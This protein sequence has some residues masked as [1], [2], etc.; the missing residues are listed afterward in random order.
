MFPYQ[1]TLS[2]VVP[3]LKKSGLNKENCSSQDLYLISS[4]F[5]K[6]LHEEVAESRTTDYLSSDHLLNTFHAKVNL[7]RLST[8]LLCCLFT[9]ALLRLW[10]NSWL[11]VLSMFCNFWYYILLRRFFSWFG[12]TRSVHSLLEW[13]IPYF[14]VFQSRNYPFSFVFLFCP[15]LCYSRLCLE[16]FTFYSLYYSSISLFSHFSPWYQS[17]TLCWWVV[18]TNLTEAYFCMIEKQSLHFLFFAD[19][20]KGKL[21]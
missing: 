9:T 7:N 18:T 10:I 19:R 6:W 16:L 4:A 12:I 13:I 17:L 14:S 11:L 20:K 8:A 15:V 5:K 1:F 21:M 3:R 2:T